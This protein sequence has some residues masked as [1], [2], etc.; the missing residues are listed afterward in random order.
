[1]NPARYQLRHPDG[2]I[3]SGIAADFKAQDAQRRDYL[4]AGFQSG[5]FRAI[6]ERPEDQSEDQ[7]MT[8]TERLTQIARRHT[9]FETL[10]TRNMDD[11]DFHDIS[12]ASF[13]AA[14]EDA[15]E[16]GITQAYRNRA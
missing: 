15:F 16:A 4:V 10:E 14:L 13:K 12:A 6:F 8:R 5:P 2:E 7:K 11:L 9:S 1:M 3:I